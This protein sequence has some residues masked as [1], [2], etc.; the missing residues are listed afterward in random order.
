[1]E[2][3][4]S[5]RADQQ[6]EVL[7]VSTDLVLKIA[8]HLD[9]EAAALQKRTRCMTIQPLA[10]NLLVPTTLP[11]PPD[12]EA[13]IPIALVD[14]HLQHRLVVTGIDADDWQSE[15]LDLAPQHVDVGPVSRP[16]RTAS[17]AF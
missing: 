17:A 2:C 5:R 13:V 4:T 10:A 11:D 3:L 9:Q 16:M 7:Q 6:T 1:M 8:L 14:L 15:G 12:A